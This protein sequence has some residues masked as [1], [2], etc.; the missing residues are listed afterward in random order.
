MQIWYTADT[1]FGHSNIIRLCGRPFSSVGEMDEAVIAAWNAVVAKD[2]EVYH[3]GDFC[4]GPASR[5]QAYLARLNGKK[6]LVHGNH[7]KRSVR[8]MP[9]WASSSTLI[10]REIEG[11]AM[12]LFHYGMRT[13]R[14]SNRGTLHLYGHS[15][16]RLPGDR[17]SCDVGVDA[18]DF[19][20]VALAEIRARLSTLPER[21]CNRAPSEYE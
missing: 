6:H 12:V 19:R 10:E 8:D 20:P 4:F 2:D 5:A 11:V 14:G 16:G 18:W 15:H 17:Q 13:W 7:D 3:L 21:G 1:H 9:H